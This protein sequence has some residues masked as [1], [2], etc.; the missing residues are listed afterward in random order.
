MG[1]H[2]ALA[3]EY[4]M[5]G[6]DAM[7]ST[8]NQ[9]RTCRVQT[10]Y[11]IA[12]C[13][14]H[15]NLPRQADKAQR[16]SRRGGGSDHILLCLRNESV[17]ISLLIPP[18]RVGWLLFSMLWTIGKRRHH[19]YAVKALSVPVQEC[20]MPLNYAQVSSNQPLSHLLLGDSF[21]QTK[22]E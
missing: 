9:T 6:Q 16:Q 13:L 17:L 18:P 11:C 22:P 10:S 8:N 5:Q 2:S 21:I 12:V 20:L 4:W 1:N 3:G 7:S 19:F 14:F 15:R